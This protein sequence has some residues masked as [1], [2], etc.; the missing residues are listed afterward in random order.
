[1]SK[2]VSVTVRL[3]EGVVAREKGRRERRNRWLLWKGFGQ[4]EKKKGW[5]LALE[6]RS[7]AWST[8]EERSCELDWWPGGVGEMCEMQWNRL[9]VVYR[10]KFCT[11]L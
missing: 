10:L 1:M 5:R 8:L 4:V 2:S 3:Q 9:V 7:V 11:V 6:S